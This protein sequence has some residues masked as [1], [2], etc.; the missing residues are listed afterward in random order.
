[1]NLDWTDF[2]TVVSLRSLKIQYIELSTRYSL[3]ATDYLAPF[4][5]NIDKTTP[6]NADQTDW[7]T[8]FKPTANQ[9][10]PISTVIADYPDFISG[11]IEAPLNKTYV[12]DLSSV[13]TRTIQSL[14][15]KTTSGSCDA[16]IKI[17][18]NNITGLSSV[19]VSSSLNSYT[20]TALNTLV[21]GDSITLVIS[22]AVAPLDL[23]FTLKYLR[24]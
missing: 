8:N 16:S 13:Q 19:S 11:Q 21:P 4:E 23:V 15:V 2:K 24:S 10:V 12:L 5:C 17:N 22:N 3:F 6:A 20:A 9:S 18:G 1:M 7:E 14:S